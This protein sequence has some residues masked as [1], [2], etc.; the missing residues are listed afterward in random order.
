[1][2]ISD[3]P[4]FLDVVNEP[5]E[6]IEAGELVIGLRPKA[7]HQ[8]TVERQPI[9]GVFMF[10]FHLFIGGFKNDFKGQLCK[11]LGSERLVVDLRLLCVC[12]PSFKRRIRLEQRCHED[13][14]NREAGTHQETVERAGYGNETNDSKTSLVASDP[15]EQS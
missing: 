3:Q 13:C 5:H 6:G 8:V 15:F 11:E 14:C 7:I 4:A 9:D 2:V 1:M 12:M 10:I